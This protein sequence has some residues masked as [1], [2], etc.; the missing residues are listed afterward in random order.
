MVVTLPETAS[1][2]LKAEVEKLSA[3]ASMDPV[4]PFNVTD[5]SAKAAADLET[6]NQKAADEVDELKNDTTT[7]NETTEEI[8]SFSEW[9]QKRMEEAEK[10]NFAN[11]SSGVGGNGKTG[12]GVKLGWKNYASPDCGAKVR[13][14]CQFYTG[15]SVLISEYLKCHKY[16]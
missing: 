8:P 11:E 15:I 5:A 4:A 1:S 12:S 7:V 16:S 14:V 9:A 3:T 10:K 6:A 2:E 13:F